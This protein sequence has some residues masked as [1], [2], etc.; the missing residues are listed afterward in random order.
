G[1][2]GFQIADRHANIHSETFSDFSVADSVRPLLWK[3]MQALATNHGIA[4]LW[5]RESS[6]FWKQNGFGKADAETLKRLPAPWA[7][8]PGEWLTLSLKNEES[9]VSLE[10]ELS[11]FMAAEKERTAQTF[12]HVKLLKVVATVVAIVLAIFVGI[13]LFYLIRKNPGILAPR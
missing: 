4:R 9:I 11:M 10:K 2:I 1:G 13:A 5:T 3:R 8:Y 7:D 12:R 6:L